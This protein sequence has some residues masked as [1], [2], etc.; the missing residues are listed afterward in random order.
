MTSKQVSN[1]NDPTKDRDQGHGFQFWRCRHGAYR[2]GGRDGQFGIVL[3]DEDAVIAITFNTGNMLSELN[4]IWHKLLPA[5]SDEPLDEAPDQL[6]KPKA[7][8][9]KLK[10]TR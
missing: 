9:E 1:G 7:T 6:A 2:G 8:F 5:F 3:P 10:A 4:I